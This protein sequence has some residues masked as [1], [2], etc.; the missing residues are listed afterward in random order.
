MPQIIYLFVFI[1]LHKFVVDRRR[2][3]DVLMLSGRPADMIGTE[4]ADTVSVSADFKAVLPTGNGLIVVVSLSANELVSC[5]NK[6]G[7]CELF[8][9]MN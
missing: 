9:K 4:L 2:D 3:K 5:N 7:R 8:G 6:Q 1:L